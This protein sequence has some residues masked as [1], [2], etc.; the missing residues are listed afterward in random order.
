[1]SPSVSG[2]PGV[3]MGV[4]GNAIPVPEVEPEDPE[5]NKLKRANGVSVVRG[6]LFNLR[7]SSSLDW[8]F[9]VVDCVVVNLLTSC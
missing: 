4:S 8:W 9:L 7:W 6:A 2:S 1:M 3:E 5:A